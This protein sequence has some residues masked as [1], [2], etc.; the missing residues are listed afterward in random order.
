MLGSV[1]SQGVNGPAG[2]FAQL[3]FGDVAVFGLNENLFQ[4]FVGHLF[5]LLFGAKFIT[6]LLLFFTLSGNKGA[7]SVKIYLGLP[8]GRLLFRKVKAGV[9]LEE[10]SI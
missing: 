4:I 10:V 5:H 6:V 2:D 9:K 1:I 8:K 3:S 7:E